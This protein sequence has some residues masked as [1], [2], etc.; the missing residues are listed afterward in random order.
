MAR[1]KDEPQGN[2]FDRTIEDQEL[3]AALEDLYSEPTQEAY[4]AY[5]DAHK[6]VYDR[7]NDMRIGPDEKLRVGKFVVTGKERRGGGF[8]IKPWTKTGVGSIS[9]LED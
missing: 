6:K 1:T 7:L 8:E 5:K 3:E 9:R 2:M 4:K